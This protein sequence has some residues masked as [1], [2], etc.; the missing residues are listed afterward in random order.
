MSVA[1]KPHPNPP[2]AE[3]WEK[4]KEPVVREENLKKQ[5]LKDRN[6]YM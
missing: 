3:Y 5:Y 6:T 2:P 4:Q 1:S